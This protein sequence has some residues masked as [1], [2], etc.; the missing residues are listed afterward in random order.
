MQTTLG[1]R[2]RPRKQITDPRC[3][4]SSDVF[5]RSCW[6][7]E[8]PLGSS[9]GRPGFDHAFILRRSTDARISTFVRIVKIERRLFSFRDAFCFGYSDEQVF[10]QAADASKSQDSVLRERRVWECQAAIDLPGERLCQ[11]RNWKACREPSNP[12]L[13]WLRGKSQHKAIL[14]RE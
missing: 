12:F 7:E 14:N 8:E 4:G 6:L 5:L 9:P 11:T 2:N 13:S 3:R 10:G 1:C